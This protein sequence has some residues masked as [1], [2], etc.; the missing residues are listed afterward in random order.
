MKLQQRRPGL[1]RAEPATALRQG[2]DDFICSG[3]RAVRQPW[4]GAREAQ[5]LACGSSQYVALS[6]CM[7]PVS[8]SR[9]LYRA[10]LMPLLLL[11]ALRCRAP[12]LLVLSESSS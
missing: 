7:Q 9:R 2:R 1:L 8:A 10:V 12:G 6:R 4:N 5:E 11:P 3:I